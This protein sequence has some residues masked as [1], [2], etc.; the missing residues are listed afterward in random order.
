MFGCALD[1]VLEGN[2]EDIYIK[3]WG[4]SGAVSY[5]RNTVVDFG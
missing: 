1:F 3:F 5:S 4:I 2:T